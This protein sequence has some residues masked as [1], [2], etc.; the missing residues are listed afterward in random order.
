M[1]KCIYYVRRSNGLWPNI[2]LVSPRVMSSP[3]WPVHWVVIIA[4]SSAIR[5]SGLMRPR[6]PLVVLA[7]VYMSA[8]R[9]LYAPRFLGV[10][11]IRSQHSCF[12]ASLIEYDIAHLYFPHPCPSGWGWDWSV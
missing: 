3:V 7:C 1:L 6:C 8:V 2:S 9:E 11:V 12:T 4:H 10:N 5:L